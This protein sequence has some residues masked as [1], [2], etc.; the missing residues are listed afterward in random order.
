VELKTLFLGLLV[1]M[2]AFAVK[3]GMGW[4]YLWLRWSGG[5]RALLT[6]GLALLYILLFAGVFL[7]VSRVNILAHYELFAPLWERGITLHWL[8]AAFMLLWGLMLLRTDSA[9]CCREGSKGWLALALPCPVCLS[10]V[11]M[12]AAGLVMYFPDDAPKAAALL[13]LCFLG[14]AAAAGLLAAAGRGPQ[15]EPLEHTLGLVM[16]LI[17]AYFIVSALVMP[18]FSQAGRVYRL[19]SYAEESE[20]R[21]GGAAWAALALAPALLVF[22][23][24]RAR[25][26]IAG[27]KGAP[28]NT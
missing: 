4:S 12:S 27:P 14:A 17:G 22:G 8:A 13:C 2:L 23:F 18:Q 9:E 19:A 24:F 6:L 10:V 21:P 15:A 7:F 26:E 11:L 25:R 28:K 5:R 3:T 16:I 1:S 20:F